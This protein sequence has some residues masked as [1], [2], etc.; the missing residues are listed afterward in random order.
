M[1]IKGTKKMKS[2]ESQKKNC[3][4]CDTYGGIFS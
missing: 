4:F 2:L 3:K 1:A